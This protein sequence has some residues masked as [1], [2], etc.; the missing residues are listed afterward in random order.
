MA[1]IE[2]AMGQGLDHWRHTLAPDFACQQP[3]LDAQYS[4]VRDL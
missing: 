2:G 4:P 3:T 1:S